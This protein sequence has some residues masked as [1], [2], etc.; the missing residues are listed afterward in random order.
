MKVS[1]S[2]FMLLVL[3]TWYFTWYS[4]LCGYVNALMFFDFRVILLT[5][6]GLNIATAEHKS[7]LWAIYVEYQV[8][9]RY[10]KLVST[11]SGLNI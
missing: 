7:H 8:D 9:S 10:T 11:W 5:S 2:S 1:C 4:T 6:C 3:P